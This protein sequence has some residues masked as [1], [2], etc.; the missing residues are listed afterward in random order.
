MIKQDKNQWWHIMQSGNNQFMKG[1]RLDDILAHLWIW[2]WMVPI[3]TLSQ[4][5]TFGY[6]PFLCFLF[7]HWKS[8]LSS[9]K[10]RKFIGSTTIAWKS[11]K[12][13]S[14][15]RSFRSETNAI[16]NLLGNQ[17]EKKGICLIAQRRACFKINLQRF[18]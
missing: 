16:N 15:L 18:K 17:W 10:K 6:R 13:K 12:I 4:Y 14:R 3:F 8:H 5:H 9:Q 2:T 1:R 11:L 7:H